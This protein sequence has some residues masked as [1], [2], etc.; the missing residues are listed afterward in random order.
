M[1]RRLIWLLMGWKGPI[2]LHAYSTG[3]YLIAFGGA[4]LLVALYPLWFRLAFVIGRRGRTARVSAWTF[5]IALGLAW[6]ALA[7]DL[8]LFNTT[9][10]ILAGLLVVLVGLGIYLVANR[11]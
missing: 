5:G 2:P 11:T 8:F 10:I 7:L 4:A 6:Y 9:I 1:I 3:E